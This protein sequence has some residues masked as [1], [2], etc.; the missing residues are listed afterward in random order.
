MKLVTYR[1]AHGPRTGALIGDQI[2]DFQRAHIRWT[3]KENDAFASIQALIEADVLQLAQALAESPHREDLVALEP[4][5]HLMAPIPVPIQ[6]RDALCFWDHMYGGLKL[7][8]RQGIDVRDRERTLRELF[9][10]RPFWYT[11]NRFSVVGPDEVITWPSYSTEMDYELEMAVVIG[12]GGRNIDPK[13]ARKHI[14]GYSIFNDF[15]ARDVQR[16]EHAFGIGFSKSKGFDNSNALGPCIVTADEFDP[17]AA[18]MI[19]RINGQ[20][21]CDNN[22]STITHKFEDVIAW[23]SKD[24]LLRPGE[25]FG[26]GTVGGGCGSEV[27][28]L[29]QDGDVIELEIEGIGSMKHTIRVGRT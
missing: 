8:E 17:Y 5:R 11:T 4:E 16:M 27:G 2:L 10:K 12:R 1:T 24:E 18:R 22:S 25:I 3:G 19:S 6:F 20:V 14:F 29:L 23:L 21:Q 28:R 15:S 13:D 9:P 7:R 26:S